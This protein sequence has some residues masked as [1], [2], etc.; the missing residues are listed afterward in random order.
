MRIVIP[1]LILSALLSC[2]E[3]PG[4]VEA[5]AR[6]ENPALGIAVAAVGDGFELESNQGETLRL[7]RSSGLPAGR[8]WFD[9]GPPSEAGVNL[10]DVVNAQR[11]QYEA[12]PGGTF[13]G[14]RELMM[15]DGRSAYYSR[16][17]FDEDGQRV[18]ELRISALH[19]SENRLLRVYYRYPA[20]DDSAERVND[21]LLLIGE[22][23]ALEAGPEP[24]LPGD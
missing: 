15:A 16:G 3:P 2:A 13:S 19:P 5:A 23:E 10:V 24:S 1:V 14:N 22:I 12:L 6:V 4:E 20:G 9:V 7:V 21:L 11:A 8:A 17:Q 18:E